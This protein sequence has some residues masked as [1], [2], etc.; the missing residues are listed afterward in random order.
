[1]KNHVIGSVLTLFLL[2]NTYLSLGQDTLYYQNGKIEIGNIKAIDSVRGEVAFQGNEASVRV[3]L[4]TNLAAIGFDKVGPLDKD[5]FNENDQIV[6]RGQRINP[7]TDFS[8]ERMIKY[9]SWMIQVDA[10]SPFFDAPSPFLNASNAYPYNSNIGIGVE[11]FITERFGLSAMSR[12]GIG[13][14]SFST[15]TIGDFYFF[16]TPFI[17]EL[18][19]EINISSRIYPGY[20]RIFSPYLAPF[21]SI[22]SLRYYHHKEFFRYENENAEPPDALYSILLEKK[23][24]GYFQVGAALGFL[25]NFTKNINLSAQLNIVSTNATTRSGEQFEARGNPVFERI[26]ADYD[27]PRQINTNGQI[28]LAYRLDH[29]IKKPT[30]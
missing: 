25:L 5:F 17:P 6:K 18:L 10:L 4:L 19:F 24:E 28:F 27:K 3:T 13:K 29:Q 9:G 26:H 15:D 7:D 8:S 21:I 2:V 12:L 20:Q 11:H 30:P 16:K 22:G 23:T 14:Q 1:M